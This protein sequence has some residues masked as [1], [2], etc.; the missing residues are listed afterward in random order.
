LNADKQIQSASLVRENCLLT[1]TK[2]SFLDNNTAVRE[3]QGPTVLTYLIFAL[4]IQ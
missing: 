1:V 3:L 4:P 2:L